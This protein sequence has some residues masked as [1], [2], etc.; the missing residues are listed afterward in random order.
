MKNIFRAEQGLLTGNLPTVW[1]MQFAN[2]IL[3]N[4]YVLVFSGFL[5]S[6]PLAIVCLTWLLST[7]VLQLT[8]QQQI[9]PLQSEAMQHEIDCAYTI[10]INHKSSVWPIMEFVG[11]SLLSPDVSRLVVI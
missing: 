4:K 1:L 7:I 10:Q 2:I 8:V 5:R 6:L 9:I 11:D 3:R